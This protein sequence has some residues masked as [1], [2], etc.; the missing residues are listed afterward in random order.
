MKYFF[1]LPLFAS[2]LLGVAQKKITFLAPD[3]VQITAD[4]YINLPEENPI[5]ILF[6]QAG[7]SRGEYL[8]IAPKLNKLGFNCIAIDQRSGEKINDIDNQTFLDASSKNK[9]TTFIDAEADMNTAIDFV[10]KTYPKATKIIIWGSSYS[11]GLALKIAGERNDIQAVLA[12]APGEYFKRFNKPEDYVTQKAQHIQIPVFITSAK[13]EKK[14]WWSIF[15]K[16][17]IKKQT[18]LFTRNRRTTRLSCIVG[19]VS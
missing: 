15:E 2:T 10:K 19:K 17:T 13:A 8:E 7:W 9:G 16:N 5:I 3:S 14:N 1:T 11:A 6:H 12:F 18:L 4:A